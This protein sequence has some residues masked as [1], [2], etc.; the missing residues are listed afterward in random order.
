LIC[1]NIIMKKLVTLEINGK[2]HELAVEPFETLLQVLR[3]ETHLKGTKRG[4]D[5]G[6]CGCCTVHV[7]GKAVYSCMVFAGSLQDRKVTTIEGLSNGSELDPL[8]TA[9]VEQGAVQ[10]GYCTC[11]MIMTAKEL[12][13]TEDRLDEEQ[14]RHGIAG[15]LCRCTGYTKIVDAIKKAGASR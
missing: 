13:A 1:E 3:K 7:D 15:N 11:G 12:L 2:H 4:C 10:C 5:S 9:F 8:Q 6:G 14:I